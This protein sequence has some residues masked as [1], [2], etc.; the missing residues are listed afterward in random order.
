MSLKSLSLKMETP[1][2]DLQFAVKELFE[3]LNE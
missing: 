2:A 3:D 1:L